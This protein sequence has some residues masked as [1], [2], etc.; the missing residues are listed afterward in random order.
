MKVKSK[1]PK[2]YMGDMVTLCGWEYLCTG[3]LN[4]L[5]VDNVKRLKK[6]TYWLGLRSM[7]VDAPV[8][9]LYIKNTE[10]PAYGW[11]FKIIKP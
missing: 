11:D 9:S 5:R 2:V 10:L 4:P 3:G 6:H 8:E 7:K 1:Y